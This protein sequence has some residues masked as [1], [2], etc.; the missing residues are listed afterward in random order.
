V[1]NSGRLGRRWHHRVLPETD[2]ER[3][4]AAE[5]FVWAT[6]YALS[7]QEAQHLLRPW[8][9]RGWPV[10]AILRAL[11]TTYHGE[12]QRYHRNESEAESFERR[13]SAWI[14]GF[15]NL[16]PS[17]IE[18]VDQEAL[19]AQERRRW[20]EEV[21]HHRPATARSLED[22]RA[23]KALAEDAYTQARGDRTERIRDSSRRVR[24][25][26]DSLGPGPTLTEPEEEFAA[27]RDASGALYSVITHRA[28]MRISG[29]DQETRETLAERDSPAR[30]VL[31]NRYRR[32]RQ[33][34]AYSQ[35]DEL[36]D[37]DA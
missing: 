21:G 31:S 10:K 25:A 28:A 1:V 26:L 5:E 16:R 3:A 33:A 24:R 11:D 22:R 34:Q 13:M 32:Y 19:D 6:G 20:H 27:E 7:P 35:L 29:L 36:T 4:L 14:D 15:G 30:R 18:A 17:P 12:P 9:D 37:P 23:A 2:I 8:F